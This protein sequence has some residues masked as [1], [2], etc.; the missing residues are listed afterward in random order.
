LGFHGVVSN[1]KNAFGFSAEK[2]AF[3]LSDPAI[4][5]VFGV[6]STISGLNVG[7]MSALNIP[8]VL[9][10][11]RLISESVGSLPVKLF[12]ERGETKE[13][14]NEHPA[15]KIV[16]RRANEWTGATTLRTD[17]TADAL[18]YGNGFAR[19]VR[20]PDGRPFELIRLLPGTV[21]VIEDTL[22]AA[23]PI[24]RVSEGGGSREYPH[25]EILHIR[26]FLSRS[27]ASF[28]REAIG[29][30]GVL[31][32]DAAQLFGSGRRPSGIISNEKPQGG[33]AGVQAVGNIRKSFREWQR[34]ASGDPL[35]MD[36]GW[37]YDTPAMTSTDSQFL[38]HRLEQ[39]REVARVFGVPPTML[40]ELTRGTWSNTEQMGAQF[41]QLCLRP[42][43]D[44]W[45]DAL[46]TVLLTEEERDSHFFEFITD[47]LMRADAASRTA[48][49][50]ALIAA[51]VLTPNEARAIL[52]YA[53]LP[54]GDELINPH[55]ISSAAPIPAPAKEP[56]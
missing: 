22:G 50:T 14:A 21:S 54:G 39:V 55:T 34:S 20:Y 15:Y 10:A 52:N 18:I 24:Y 23:P 9:Q 11:V 49:M 3:V 32:R 45:T 7:G 37:K 4:S 29:L 13:A 43:L 1:L 26:S 44:T 41:L 51:R 53:P 5:E 2:K 27:P 46:A 19:V 38:E 16:H 8:A 17:L 33:E 35:I 42:W 36:S 56:A 48:N 12:R 28:G 47:D 31:E 40:F 30:A 6:R 25:T